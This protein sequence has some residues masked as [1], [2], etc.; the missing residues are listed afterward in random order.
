MDEMKR[1]LLV[2]D[3]SDVCFVLGDVLSE[4]G[5]V[6]DSYKD[7]LLAL[8]NFKAHS[9]SLVILDIRMPGLN[10]FVLYRGIR[11]LDIKVKICFLTT[12]EM[13]YGYSDIFSSVPA[14]HFIRKPIDNEE[15]MKRIN[16]II[17]DNTNSYT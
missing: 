8:S 1:I 11:R 14:N 2:D 15:L 5:F 3:E 6:V 12:G 7:P 16:E 4:D 10:G 17:V 9:Y 13:Y